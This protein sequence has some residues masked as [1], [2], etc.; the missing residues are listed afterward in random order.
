MFDDTVLP[1]DPG[2][3]RVQTPPRNI[4]MAEHPFPG[5][6]DD[7]VFDMENDI[8]EYEK[9]SVDSVEERGRYGGSSAMKKFNGPGLKM[10]HR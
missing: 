7:S 6:A 8:D 3:I 4:T 10:N 1:K 2:F 5:A 9:R